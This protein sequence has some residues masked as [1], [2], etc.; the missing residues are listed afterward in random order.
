MDLCNEVYGIERCKV[1]GRFILFYI[2]MKV[3]YDY[4]ILALI[5]F[6]NDLVVL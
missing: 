4:R 2:Y 6:V 5:G 1:L 3:V